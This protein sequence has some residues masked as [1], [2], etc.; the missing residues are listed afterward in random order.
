MGLLSAL[1]GGGKPEENQQEKQEQKNFEI[2]KYDGIRA[3]NMN[4]LGY[5]AKCLEQAAALRDDA[6][7][8]Q[9][10]ADVYIK[11]N[12]IADAR[13][14]LDKLKELEPENVRALLTLAHVCYM[15]EDYEGM[16]AVCQQAIGQDADNAEAYYLAAKAEHELHNDLQAIVMSTKALALNESFVPAYQFRAEVLWGMRQAKEALEDLDRILVSNPEEEDAL[17]LKGTIEA[18]QGNAGEAYACIDKVT[19]VN[20]FNEKAYLLKGGM[21][22]EEKAF[23]KAIEVYTEAL[24][25]MP[26]N[27]VLYQERGRVRLLAG[28]KDGSV[29]D[30][31]KAIELN[32]E[33][34]Q[35]I[36]GEFKN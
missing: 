28:D 17:L 12:R 6:E 34:E 32:P 24:E 18:A 30:M 11:M 25:L 1:F 23:E 26:D 2:L 5:A 20:P 19:E 9:F 16:N 13:I 35:H 27:A 15:Q 10:L 8:L 22:C 31:K 14:T 33:N 21:L 7:T 29:E 3:R 36:N 4:Q